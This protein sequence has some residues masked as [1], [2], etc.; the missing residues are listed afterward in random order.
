M[1]EKNLQ[2]KTIYPAG[3]SSRF[4]GE[5]KIFTGKQKLRE[6]STIKQALQQMLEEL[7]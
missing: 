5:I 6:C 7:L 2:Q 1:K 3:L 4:D